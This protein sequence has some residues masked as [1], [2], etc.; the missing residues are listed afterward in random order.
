ME[1]HVNNIYGVAATIH[2]NKHGLRRF[3]RKLDSEDGGEQSKRDNLKDPLACVER[4][5]VI[6][7]FPDRELDPC[8]SI[9]VKGS[10]ED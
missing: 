3:G 1:D 7:E 10:N 4:S 2:Q 9:L 8:K 6:P 5:E